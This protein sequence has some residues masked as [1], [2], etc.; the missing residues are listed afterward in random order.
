MLLPAELPCCLIS[1]FENPVTFLGALVQD[2]RDGVFF[3]SLVAGVHSL[4]VQESD[5]AKVQ[6]DGLIWRRD[7]PSWQVGVRASDAQ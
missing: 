2:S 4:D 6:M 1:L 3:T 7:S 5:P